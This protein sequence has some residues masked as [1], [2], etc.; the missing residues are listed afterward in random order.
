MNCLKWNFRQI[1][2]SPVEQEYHNFLKIK[3][4]NWTSN[5]LMEVYYTETIKICK[6]DFKLFIISQRIGTGNNTF[7]RLEIK[8]SLIPV[9]F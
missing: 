2:E 7:L 3:M 6:D 1:S 8:H 4:E 5:L 9:Y